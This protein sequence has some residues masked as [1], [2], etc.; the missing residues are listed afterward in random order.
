M[1]ERNG[2]ILKELC[3]KVTFNWKLPDAFWKWIENECTFCNT[4]VDRIVTGY[5]HGEEQELN[6]RLGYKDE[7]MTVAEPFHLFVID[8][9]G[10]IQE[11]LPFKKAGLNVYFDDI[12]SYRELKVKLLNAP[13]TILASI[14]LLS[15]METVKQGIEELSPH[16]FFH[17]LMSKE[18]SHTLKPEGKMR[19]AE[20]MKDV[21]DR[22][23]NPF[24]HHRLLDISLNG[25]AKFRTRVLPCIIEYKRIE[26]SYPKRLLFSLAALISFYRVVEEDGQ[27]YFGNSLTGNYEIRDSGEVISKFVGFWSHY[28]GTLEKTIKLVKEFVI[29][30]LLDEDKLD[31]ANELAVEVSKLL[32][33]IQE[34]GIQQ[35]LEMVEK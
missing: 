6:D 32:T 17:N 21:I 13:H 16:S 30:D 33:V 18:L 12:E 34:L 23:S 10:H 5:P 28:D 2:E 22:F 19:S 20:Y 11:K 29:D 14:G 25:Y 7:L 9:P 26:G 1:V 15:G 8:A 24:L 31:E 4:L 35:A 27:K 3:K